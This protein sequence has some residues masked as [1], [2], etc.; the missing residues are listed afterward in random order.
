MGI[1]SVN[2]FFFIEILVLYVLLTSLG[3]VLQNRGTTIIVHLQMSSLRPIFEKTIFLYD[4][5]LKQKRILKINKA[6]K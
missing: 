3:L 1:S 5:G 2:V 6:T 4:Q